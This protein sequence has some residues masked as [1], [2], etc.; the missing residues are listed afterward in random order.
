[1]SLEASSVPF[2]RQLGLAYHRW[3]LTTWLIIFFSL[4][5]HLVVPERDAPSYSSFGSY[6]IGLF[7]MKEINDYSEIQTSP[8]TQLLDKVKLYSFWWLKT[9]N[10]SLISNYHSWWSSPFTCLGMM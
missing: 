8:L 1:L 7:G 6:V 3:I 4:L 9:T 2:G 5:I 10:I